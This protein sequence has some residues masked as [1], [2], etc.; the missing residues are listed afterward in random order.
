MCHN[1]FGIFGMVESEISFF[2]CH[3]MYFFVL[4]NGCILVDVHASYR[5]LTSPYK[6]IQHFIT[7][8]INHFAKQHCG[9]CVDSYIKLK[10]V[11]PLIKIIVMSRL[12]QLHDVRKKLI[13][14]A[15]RMHV[16]TNSKKH[17]QFNIC[18]TNIENDSCT[19]INFD[20]I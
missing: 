7:K 17:R 15:G 12:F 9:L 13:I 2:T 16:Q 20:Y 3:L 19:Q 11:L 6:S 5:H 4:F 18:F 1:I 8:Y 10:L 14:F